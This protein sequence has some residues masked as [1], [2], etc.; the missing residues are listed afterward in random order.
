MLYGTVQV[1]DR[2]EGYHQTAA[3]PCNTLHTRACIMA[4]RT[5]KNNLAVIPSVVIWLVFEESLLRGVIIF[6]NWNWEKRL[7]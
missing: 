7:T 3:A 4:D 6:S 1:Q 5:V 2:Q